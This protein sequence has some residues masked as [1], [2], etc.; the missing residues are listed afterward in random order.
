VPHESALET[1]A[2]R[3]R[4]RCFAP[5]PAPVERLRRAALERLAANQPIDPNVPDV[6]VSPDAHADAVLRR[7][8]IS[9]VNAARLQLHVVRA[10]EPAR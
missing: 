3:Q 9:H 6:W 10:A 4:S 1:A 7:H 8:G 5:S 2:G